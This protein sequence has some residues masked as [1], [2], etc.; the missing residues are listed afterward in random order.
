MKLKLELLA[1][2]PFTGAREAEAKCLM[3]DGN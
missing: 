3:R 1:R 2:I